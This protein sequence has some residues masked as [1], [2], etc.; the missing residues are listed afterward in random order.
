MIVCGVVFKDAGK[1]YYFAK[2]DLSVKENDYVIVETEKGEQFGKA[3]IVEERKVENKLKNVLRIANN[4]DYNKY[5]KLLKESKEALKIAKKYAQ[6]LKLN[7]QFVDATFTF[8]HKQLIINFMA[9][10]RID[11]RELVKLLA[12]KYKL[13]IDLH[14]I[15]ARDKAKE[16]GGIGPCGRKLCCTSYLNH[17]DTISINMAKNQNIALNPSK[18][19]GACGRLLCCLSYEDETYTKCRE[20]LPTVNENVIYEGKNYQVMSVNIFKQTYTIIV[21]GEK[22]EI[23]INDKK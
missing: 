5:L 23:S 1:I 20:T 2:N 19:N 12:A 11:F 13:R 6:D 10:E 9:D 21:D 15:G 18:I 4:N 16:Q 14:Q 22:K 7:M 17:L 3:I 8:D